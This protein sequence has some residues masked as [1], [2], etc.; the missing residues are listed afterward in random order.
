TALTTHPGPVLDAFRCRLAAPGSQAGDVLR[1]LGEETS[2][3]VAAD[4]AEFVRALLRARPDTA[5]HV[6]AYA[7]RRL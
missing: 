2:P 3:A 4:I 1:V 7:E 6:A 5:G